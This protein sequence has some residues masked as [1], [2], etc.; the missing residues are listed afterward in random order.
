[1]PLKKLRLKTAEDA[2][3]KAKS[4]AEKAKT[5]IEK[6]KQKASDDPNSLVNKVIARIE[7]E[8]NQCPAPTT[9]PAPVKAASKKKKNVW[10]TDDPRL[11]AYSGKER[12]LI[13]KIFGVIVA[14]T[15]EK[16]AE[17]LIEKIEDELQ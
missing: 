2:V 15:D 17:M 16:T 1:M 4:A 14:S 13:S 5:T 10:R 9:N 7:S 3:A 11:S 8:R 6:K 12:K